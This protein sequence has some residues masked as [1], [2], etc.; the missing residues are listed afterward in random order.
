MGQLVAEYSAGCATPRCD[1]ESSLPHR[2]HLRPMAA[3]QGVF[4]QILH[5]LDASTTFLLSSLSKGGH[6]LCELCR[7][8]MVKP[9]SASASAC[10]WRTADSLQLSLTVPWQKVRMPDRN[11]N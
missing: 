11:M 8:V 1:L 4:T 9:G 7:C 2:M 10:C 3:E 5:I 6:V